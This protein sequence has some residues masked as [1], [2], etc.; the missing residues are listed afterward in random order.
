VQKI[1]FVTSELSRQTAG[2]P[3]VTRLIDSFW[4]NPILNIIFQRVFRINGDV[5]IPVNF[6]SRVTAYKNIELHKDKNTLLS[7]AVSGGCYIQAINGIKIG[8][9]FLFAPGVK[10]ISANHQVNNLEIS[11]FSDKIIIGN[12]VW[13]GA[14]AIILPGV[15]IGNNCIIGAGSVVTK[16]FS[17]D[18]LVIAGNPAKIIKYLE[19]Q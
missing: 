10:I 15:K 11:E 1:L 6:T 5:S 2:T 8:E 19:K 13:I 14:N 16:S 12:N 7:F 9:N 3:R 17:D 4:V 18:Y